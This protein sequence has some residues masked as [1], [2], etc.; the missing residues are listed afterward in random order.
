MKTKWLE[1]EPEIARSLMGSSLVKP[2]GSF[3]D[4]DGRAMGGYNDGIFRADTYFSVRGSDV[5]ICL[6]RVH[7]TKH[8][9]FLAQVEADA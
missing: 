5:E 3:T 1:C 9:Y 4:C 2:T 8:R 6:H 7:G